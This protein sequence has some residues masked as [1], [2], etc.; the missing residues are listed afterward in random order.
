MALEPNQTTAARL[1]DRLGERRL[2]HAGR[3]FEQQGTTDTD[4]KV[5]GRGDLIVGDVAGR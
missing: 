5:D 4:R 3:A 2:A 1:G